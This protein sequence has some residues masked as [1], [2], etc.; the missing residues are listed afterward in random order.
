MSERSNPP[1]SLALSLIL[2]SGLGLL[3]VSGSCSRPSTPENASASTAST[4]T[5]NPLKDQAGGASSDDDDPYAAFMHET[6]PV[7]AHYHDPELPFVEISEGLPHS[8]TWLGYPLLFDFDGDGRADLVAS[9]R[10]ED[11][12]S[13]WRAPSAEGKPWTRCI[14]AWDP[15]NNPGLSRDMGYGPAV[16][17]D[18]NS[19]GIPDLALSAHSDGLHVFLNDGKLRWKQ[20]PGTIENP[21]LWIDIAVGHLDLD[22]HLDV[23]AIGQFKG[24]ISVWLGDGQG[25]LRRLPESSAVLPE[26]VI[27]KDIE[28]VDIDGDGRDDIVVT[29]D[30]GLKVF[31]TSGTD[32]LKWTDVS[33]GLPRPKIGNSLTAVT[34]GRFSGGKHPDLAT[35]MLSDP[36]IVP[37][38]RD[39]IGV[40]TWREKSVETVD[41]TTKAKHVDMVRTWEQI[42]TGLPRSESY[43]DVRAADLDGDGN[44][45]LL[46][47]SIESGAVIYLGDGKGGFS[48]KGRLKGVHGKGRIAFG[49]VDHDGRMDIAIAVP[50]NKDHPEG[51]GLRVF[52]NRPE[53]WKK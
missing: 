25:G 11:G 16:A 42:D 27:G 44:L 30:A 28:L 53:I 48:A 49:D 41:E 40:W 8:G 4:P 52:L 17:G 38:K 33:T 36:G 6:K 47:M 9:N 34:V 12:V 19:D 32:P 10:E 46:A 37:S 35:C 18:F 14:D 5:A 51:G 50:A 20:A 3:P 43:R 22:K 39:N 1:P 23:A 15:K 7:L 26:K 31:L 2:L 21:N 45:D 24:G 29:T 13:A